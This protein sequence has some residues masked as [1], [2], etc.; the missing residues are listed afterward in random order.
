MTLRNYLRKVAVSVSVL[1]SS[2]LSS[3]YSAPLLV[4]AKDSTDISFTV[5]TS[6]TDSEGNSTDTYTGGKVYDR[7]TV[8]EVASVTNTGASCYLRAKIKTNNWDDFVEVSFGSDWV[9][10][11]DGY[12]YYTNVV[13]SKETVTIFDSITFADGIV[14]E[15]DKRLSKSITLGISVDAV[16]DAIAPDFNSDTPWNASPSE[17]V[18]KE[19]NSF[20]TGIDSNLWY[21]VAVVLAL[22]SLLLLVYLNKQTILSH[23]QNK[24]IIFILIV[25]LVLIGSISLFTKGTYSYILS[26]DKVI[27][28]KIQF[29]KESYAATLE[30]GTKFNAH[31][32]DTATE[33]IFTDVAAPSGASLIDVSEAQD[34]SI[35]AWLA[36]TTFY[37]STQDSAGKIYAN[38][39]CKDMFYNKKSIETIQF[40][41]FDTSNTTSMF[42]MFKFCTNLKSIDLSS[43][44]TRNV[45][46][47]YYMFQGC[48]AL[49]NLDVSAF[50]T[51]KV[52]NMAGMFSSC[53]NLESID[54]SNFD[55][56][57]VT[58]MQSMFQYCSNM[59]SLDCS[60]FD[61]SSLESIYYMFFGCS[62]L[63]SLNLN[64]FNTEKVDSF[65][66]LFR[67]CSS[68][69][70]IDVSSFDTSNATGFGSMFRECTS[71]VNLN[72]TNFDT[73]K[74]T[75]CSYMFSGCSALT[76]LDITNFDVSNVTT[77][78]YMFKSCAKLSS[79]NLENFYTSKATSM[80]AMFM[81]CSSIKELDVEALDLSNVTNTDYMFQ[82][83][84]SLTTL[85]IIDS[86]KSTKSVTSS[87]YMFDG[88][89]S[90]VGGIK[91][92]SSKIDITYYKSSGGYLTVAPYSYAIKS[93]DVFR[94]QLTDSITGIVFTTEG[95]PFWAICS[96]LSRDDSVICWTNQNILYVSVTL[97]YDDIYGDAEEHFIHAPTDMTGMFKDLPNVTSI[98]FTGLITDNTTNMKDLFSGSTGLT[99]LDLSTFTFDKVTNTSRMFKNCSNLTTIYTSSN[100]NLSAVINST[101]MFAGCT[102]LKGAKAFDVDKIDFKYFNLSYYLT[103]K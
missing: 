48:N 58:T 102:S 68:L 98:D 86:Y 12:Y 8:D 69:E 4:Y 82:N 81:N 83:M 65:D 54:L 61:T 66:S 9:E 46:S 89:T 55:T 101:D 11:P 2:I 74:A 10:K 78:D 87:S 39:S 25:L 41:N 28:R 77:F 64:G 62:N 26:T 29:A 22:F 60:M 1:L 100:P 84:S 36:D 16:A 92:N 67:S 73:S 71:L 95:A 97:G 59:K 91:Y 44:D 18:T 70:K 17:I 40:L 90:L 21:A 20:S 94:E 15:S 88:C 33:V 27:E 85:S 35:V 49:S 3:S 19:T 103:Q 43:F 31:I 57:K 56:S 5:N 96:G 42:Q 93:V 53:S 7:T 32:P 51:S 80:T 30:L 76:E 24:S 47:M 75:D 63:V 38:K 45:T 6:F 79:L 37:V 13:A 72:L 50:D 23:L 99:E 14:K 52:T 34:N